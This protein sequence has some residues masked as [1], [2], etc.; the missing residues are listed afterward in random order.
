LKLT[1]VTAVFNAV[2]AG[3]RE[4]LIRC[5]KS[6]ASVKTDH[7]H[8][9]VDGAS[10][11]GTLELLQELAKEYPSLKIISGPDTGIYNALNKGLKAAEGEWFYVLGC[12]DSFC[13]PEVLDE[14]LRTASPRDEVLVAPVEYE[15]DP[16]YAFHKMEDLER[17]LRWIYGY[18]H[19]GMLVKTELA[20]KLGGFDESYRLCSDGDMMLKLHERHSRFRY[21]FKA[22]AN[23][24]PG[25]ANE[26][27]RDKVERETVL[28]LKR[29]LGLTD[30]EAEFLSKSWLP[31]VRA[32]WRHLF[33]RDFA[34]RASA[35][36][37]LRE[38][39]KD[40]L[41]SL[42]SWAYGVRHRAAKVY[43]ASHVAFYNRGGFVGWIEPCK[44]WGTIIWMDRQRADVL[45][46]LPRRLRNRAL[47]I[48]LRV[49][50]LRLK[51]FED[52]AVSVGV[53][54]QMLP[55]RTGGCGKSPMNL[56]RLAVPRELNSGRDGLELNL[57][58]RKTPV[59]LNTVVPGCQDPRTLGMAIQDIA[60]FT[61]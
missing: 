36:C 25:G 6:V 33:S 26:N 49:L 14:L 32:I 44:P 29:H 15:K 52:Q 11:D 8:I 20:R 53:G 9:M 60:L 37:I 30:T 2:K 4:K 61:R 10:T 43:N 22:F 56:V 7:E 12:D 27:A 42:Q 59:P 40:W 23:F 3:N 54:G 51:G 41:L 18:C 58:L 24:A 48:E 50:F 45:L 21:T 46:P 16:N 31:P 28:I 39:S 57:E 13:A 1:C 34:F 19:Q 55:A 38:R 17:V 5:V 47:D 35:R